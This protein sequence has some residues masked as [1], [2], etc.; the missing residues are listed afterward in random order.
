MLRQAFPPITSQFHLFLFLSSTVFASPLRL[1]C[2]N[3]P[4]QG[5]VLDVRHERFV[6]SPAIREKGTRNQY[7]AMTQIRI[8][9]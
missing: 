9:D 1:T 2:E 8:K 5:S 4:E 7:R 3:P 6:L